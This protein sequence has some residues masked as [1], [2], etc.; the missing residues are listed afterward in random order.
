MRTVVIFL[1]LMVLAGCKKKLIDPPADLIPQDRMTEILYDLAVLNG[2]KSTNPSFLENYEIETMPYLYK[3]HQ[4]D[5]VQFVRSDQYYASIPQ[6]Y[7]SMY[8]E[9]QKR[10]EGQVK[11]IDAA[12]DQR[13]DSIR[14][15]NNRRRDSLNQGKKAN[16]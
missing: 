7:Q 5:S 4:V 13:N 6:L 11:L 16:P 12:R 14:S 10:L 2:I 8:E 1:G 3:K 9:I 15:M